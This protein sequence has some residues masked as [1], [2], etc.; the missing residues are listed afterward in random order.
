[1]KPIAG[2][3]NFEGGGIAQSI[4]AMQLEMNIMGIFSEN[5]LGFDKVGYQKKEAVIS[6]FAE[7]IGSN[8]L[9]YNVDNQVGRLSM[10]ERPLD[11]ALSEKGYFQVLNNDGSIELTRDGRFKLNKDGELL[12]QT[13]QKVLSS[14]GAPIVFPRV[15][16]KLESIKIGLD[17]KIGIFDD[18][19]RGLVPA[20][21]I[22]VVSDDGTLVSENCVRQGYVEN[23]NVALEKEYIEMSNYK[24][25]FEMNARMFRLQNSRLSN[26]IQTLGRV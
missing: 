20:G 11:L 8:A 14:G 3:I 15:P 5:V 18:E 12:T 6:S 9:S 16:E 22:G 13:D 17:G 21:T 10:T 25:S 2:A 1:M 19:T 23:S 7:Y 24:R 26:A 4:N